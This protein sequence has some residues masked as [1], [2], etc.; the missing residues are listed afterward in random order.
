MDLNFEKLNFPASNFKLKEEEGKLK[1]F[2]DSRRKYIALT[3][4]EWVRQNC[5]HYLRKEKGFPI[6]LLAIEK[7]F[8]K[9]LE[10]FEEI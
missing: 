10:L 5:L 3:P 2:D 1:I 8:K 7:S 4:E 9:T 6:S